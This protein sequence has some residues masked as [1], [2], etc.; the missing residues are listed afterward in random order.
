MSEPQAARERYEKFEQSWPRRFYERWILPRFADPLTRQRFKMLYFVWGYWRFLLVPGLGVGQ[1]LGLLRRFL[2]IDWNVVHCHFP[3]ETS[4]IAR[5]LAERHARPGE[6]VVE[7]G[8]WQGGTSTKFSLLCAAL[9][10]HLHVYDSF[11]GVET[12]SPDDQAKEW[13]FAGQYA[14]P[15]SRL[16]DNLDRYGAPEECTVHKGWF[17]ETLAGAPTDGP[18][19]V[20]YIDCDLG[21]GTL[22]VLQSVVPALAEDGC[23]FSQDF[24]IEPVRRVLI[25]PETWRSLGVPSPELR[26]EG[27]YLASLRPTR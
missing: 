20:A 9:G 16:R 3:A 11:E 21:K 14:S 17:S 15:E 8:C 19:R 22:E 7:A 18:V 26:Q 5:V 2:R 12:L 25:D 1:R 6:I 4:C 24:H 27:V 23:I 13:D 10:Y